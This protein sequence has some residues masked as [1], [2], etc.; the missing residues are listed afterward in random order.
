M[1]QNPF[2]ALADTNVYADNPEPRCPCLLLLDV[3][4]SMQG[5]PIKQL[6]GGLDVYRESLLSDPLARK[7]V[8]VAILTFG[9]TVERKQ[10]FVNVDAL[11]PLQFHIQGGTPMATA[12]VEGLKYLE[13]QKGVYR[14]QGI[15]YYR[16]WVFLITDGE[17]TDAQT[18][19]W[20]QA[21][22]Q[23]RDGERSKA[24]SFFAVGVE[25]A[26][27]IRLKELSVRDPLKL[28]GLEFR[29]LFAW[30]SASQQAVSRSSPGEGVRLP[31]PAGW[32]EV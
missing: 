29:K 9:G 6:A 31:S 1:E 23:V 11:P 17:P 10:P 5:E 30:L 8:E 13:S 32:A 12:V 24:F 4:S 22:R 20:G 7:R 19:F 3:S 28:K 27:F 16:P 25:G 18:E 26:N 2:L 15:A 14:T 21:V